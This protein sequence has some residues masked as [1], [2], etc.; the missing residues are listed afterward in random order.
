MRI[1]FPIRCCCLPFALMQMRMITPEEEEEEDEDHDKEMPCYSCHRVGTRYRT[2]CA[3]PNK[4][5]FGKKLKLCLTC[6]HSNTVR[7]HLANILC[8]MA[9]FRAKQL[10]EIDVRHFLHLPETTDALLHDQ[11]LCR[12]AKIKS[13]S[14]RN[15]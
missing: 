5:K 13:P 10:A 11:H 7:L 8:K 14:S 6:C 2:L 4:P 9:G 15:S 1:F 12:T 3:L